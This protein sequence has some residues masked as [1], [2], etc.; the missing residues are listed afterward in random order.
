MDSD[1]DQFQRMER[2][3]V[4]RQ[5]P[6]IRRRKRRSKVAVD[7]IQIEEQ[8]EAM[9][10]QTILSPTDIY[11]QLHESTLRIHRATDRFLDAADVMLASKKTVAELFADQGHPA[12]NEIKDAID[13]GLSG[14][15]TCYQSYL[16][17]PPGS[18]KL[19]LEPLGLQTKTLLMAFLALPPLPVN[20]LEV[21][22]LCGMVAEQFRGHRFVA[23]SDHA[24]A[25]FH[26]VIRYL[27]QDKE[28][29]DGLCQPMEVLFANKQLLLR[30]LISSSTADVTAQI[31]ACRGTRMYKLLR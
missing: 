25:L 7:P 28:T 9:F 27:D 24:V 22:S 2:M 23:S 14:L 3:Q 16:C 18:N 4:R 6:K 13:E 26:N 8:E 5:S 10:F 1:H 17:Q 12:S 31:K 30:D 21:A 15:N 11:R 19:D 20:F 29:L